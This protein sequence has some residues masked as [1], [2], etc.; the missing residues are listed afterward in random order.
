MTDEK[1]FTEAEYDQLAKA[2]DV[3]EA[4]AVKYRGLYNDVIENRITKMEGARIKA[5]ECASRVSGNTLTVNPYDVLKIAVIFNKYILVGLATKEG[6][7]E[8]SS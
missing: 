3:S 2:L 1:M 6:Q 5:L 8:S 4:E 7:D